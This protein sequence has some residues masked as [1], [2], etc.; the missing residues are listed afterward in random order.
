MIS[1]KYNN[2]YDKMMNIKNKIIK[3]NINIYR[4]K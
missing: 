2:K 4:N 1:D 3:K